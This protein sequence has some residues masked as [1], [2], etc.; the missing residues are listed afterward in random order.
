MACDS[1]HKYLEDVE[2]LKSVG[3]KLY[4][5]SLSWARILPT[6]LPNS[7]NQKG[8]DYYNNLINALLE[9]D[10]QPLIT[11]YHWDLPQ[12]LQDIGGWANKKI[13]KYFTDYARVAF[14]HFGD[15]V[16]LWTTINEPNSI[17]RAGYGDAAVAP[18]LDSDGIGEYQCG[19][20]LIN[21]HASVYHLFNNEY[22]HKINGKL[23]FVMDCTNMIAAT[24]SAEN[25]AAKE[26]AFQF[27]VILASTFA[28]TY[29]SVTFSSRSAFICILY[30]TLMETIRK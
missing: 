11:L 8:I 10:I 5:F 30:Y 28:S 27:S 20:N 22:K 23:G 17:C 26:Q 12:K 25:L 24:D 9:N 15:R 16:Q 7:I 14:D 13:V 19:H 4:R 21:A 6:G 29:S 1:Y 2:L 3:A 18:V